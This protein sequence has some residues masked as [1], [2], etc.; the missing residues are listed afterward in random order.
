MDLE[1]FYSFCQGKAQTQKALANC[2][3]SNSFYFVFAKTSA[4]H[5]SWRHNHCGI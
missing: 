2:D 3:K 1:E 5:R 4:T